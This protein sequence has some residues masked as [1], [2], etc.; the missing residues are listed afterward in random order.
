MKKA[1]ILGVGNAQV[2]IIHYLKQTGWWVIG[3]SYKQEGKGLDFIDQFELI[4]IKDTTGI[5]RVAQKAQ[6]DLL[7][8][9][10]SDLAMP[11]VAQIAPKL[12]LPYFFDYETALLLQNK[13][14]LREFLHTHKISQI[15]YRK[16]SILADLKD[17]IYFPAI[18]KPVDSQGQRGVFR[19]NSFQEIETCLEDSQS[20]S[21][22]KT[23]IIEEFLEGP[24]ISVN[25][26]VLDSQVIFNEISDRLVVEGYPG[27]IPKAHVFP[28]KQC[29]KDSSQKTKALVEKCIQL[30]HIKNGPV[31]FQLKLTSSGP[32][33]VEITP[34]LDGCH[35]WRLIKMVS[36]I[37]L[38]DASIRL[39][40]G[41]TSLNWQIAPEMQQHTL[42]FL[43]HPPGA[44]FKKEEYSIPPQIAYLEY[45]YQDGE[46]IRPINGLLE[47]VGYYIDRG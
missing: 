27:G 32:K 44:E 38:L 41:D 6:I 26:F 5:E 36:G 13:V 16:I 7:Y 31:Y 8:S 12:G 33:I 21:M 39:L 14:L 1:L 23:A 3:C 25:A 35:L 22:S 42:K 4:D 37:D 18:L 46:V 10:G 19:V 9:I 15:K 2:D 11:T 40:T 30:L 43:L 20:F 45:Y 28:T 17:W 29:T 24:E 47:K 34:R